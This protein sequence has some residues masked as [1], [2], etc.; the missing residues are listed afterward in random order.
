MQLSGSCGLRQVALTGTREG[1]WFH[2][3]NDDH[4]YSIVDLAVTFDRPVDSYWK[5]KW[6]QSIGTGHVCVCLHTCPHK[7]CTQNEQTAKMH[8]MHAPS[9]HRCARCSVKI[10]QYQMARR[11]TFTPH[12]STSPHLSVHRS[13]HWCAVG[14]VASFGLTPVSMWTSKAHAVHRCAQH[15]AEVKRAETRVL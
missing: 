11:A 4:R 12:Y 5:W 1:R 13:V 3:I 10:D 2:D 7:Q 6:Q 15:D 9:M 8:C 14:Q